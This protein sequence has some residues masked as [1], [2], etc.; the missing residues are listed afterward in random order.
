MQTKG[1][2]LTIA[3][4][5]VLI[6]IF[7]LSFS[8]VA[9]K[10][11]NKAIQT[12]MQANGGVKD[13]GSQKYKDAYNNYIS[14]IEKQKV[15]LGYDYKDVR[16]KQLGLGLDLKGGMNVTLEIR[17][18]NVLKS[19][20]GI[21]KDGQDKNFDKAINEVNEESDNFV[22]EFCK[23]YNATGSNVKKLFEKRVQ[24]IREHP[25]AA[26]EGTHLA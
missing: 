7:Y 11:E 17:V 1:F 20:A 24:K 18:P 21:Q 25:G 9:N 22:A 16:E 12:A 10:W 23:K 19:L 15:W 3:S 14:K 4:A 13:E 8:F 6:C 26:K 2:I 5:L